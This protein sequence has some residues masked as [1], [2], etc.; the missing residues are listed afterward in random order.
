MSRAP[1]S[2]YQ[3]ELLARAR[4]RVAR[5]QVRHGDQIAYPDDMQLM[6]DLVAQIES[7][8]SALEMKKCASDDRLFSAARQALTYIESIERRSW[9]MSHAAERIEIVRLLQATKLE[10][11]KPGWTI[12][13]ALRLLAAQNTGDG[14][15]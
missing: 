4:A 2:Q 13:R 14:A 12:L 7:L 10:G 9:R 6:L 5:S 15:P 11:E 3:I 8:T 1:I